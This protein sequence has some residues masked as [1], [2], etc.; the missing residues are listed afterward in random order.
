MWVSR[1]SFLAWFCLV[2]CCVQE[3]ALHFSLN[4]VNS[5]WALKRICKHSSLI[6]WKTAACRELLE[7][8]L[9]LI[10]PSLFHTCI[11]PPTHPPPAIFILYCPSIL[12]TSSAQMST[13]C[14]DWKSSSTE[15]LFAMWPQNL[16][17]T[18]AKRRRL[19]GVCTSSHNCSKKPRGE[20]EECVCVSAGVCV[21]VRWNQ[22]QESREG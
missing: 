12:N 10:H 4:E 18:S 8:N 6:L 11:P 7:I 21:C 9:L 13:S 3:G 20:W 19:S 22:W 14:R 17:R 16:G 1:F 5:T 2:S 15:S